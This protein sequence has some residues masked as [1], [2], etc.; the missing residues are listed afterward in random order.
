MVTGM[1]IME[2]RAFIPMPAEGSPP[3]GTM[4]EM[5]IM[6]TITVIAIMIMTVVG[7]TGIIGKTRTTFI[8]PPIPPARI[9]TT[10]LPAVCRR[11]VAIPRR[12]LLTP[13]R[14]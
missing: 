5:V 2:A 4:A 9:T 11:P 3:T 12:R 8:G 10:W 13:L 6:G 14:R 7:I 1:V